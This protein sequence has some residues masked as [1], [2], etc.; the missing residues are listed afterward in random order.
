M[1][2]QTPLPSFRFVV[3][4]TFS[5]EPLQPGITFWARQLKIPFE[6]RFAPY[7]QVLQSLLDPVG[8]LATN[9]HG[10]NVLLVRL[11]DLAEDSNDLA[12]IEAAVRELIVT[13]R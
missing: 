10:L 6:S 12:I 9:T 13:L 8:E 1:A 5:A 11:E 7:N 3:S 4:A 2:V